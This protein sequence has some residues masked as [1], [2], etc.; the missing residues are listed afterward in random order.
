[1][2]R[3]VGDERAHS[4]QYSALSPASELCG[5]AEALWQHRRRTLCGR[6]K[7][8]GRGFS[9]AATGARA[10][11]GRYDNDGWLDFLVNNNGQEAQLFRN[12]GQIGHSA[13]TTGKNHW[14]GV[15]LVG[16]KSN[17]DA[18]GAKLKIS[19]G[20]FLSTDQVKGG[21]SYM[22]AQDPRIYFG[23]GTHA[24][25]DSIEIAWPSGA[26]EIVRDLAADQIVTI[27]EGQG[28]SAYR[29]PVVHRKN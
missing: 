18:I 4:G 24:Q 10:R 28:L 5:A 9:R 23:L 17:R 27:V 15:H 1:M 20:D 2:A 3:P 13:G 26:K 29:C 21:M 25:V 22:S 7:H 14:L 19:A 16:T 8:S 12:A 6:D 11:G